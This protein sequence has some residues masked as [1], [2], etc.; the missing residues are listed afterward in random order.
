M[1]EHGRINDGGENRRGGKRHERGG[2]QASLKFRVS[3]FDRF[4]SGEISRRSEYRNIAMAAAD[5]Q[6]L[7]AAALSRNQDRFVDQ[8]SLPPFYAF[9]KAPME[10]SATMVV[11]ALRCVL[12]RRDYR[13]LS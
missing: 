7:A 4:S 2:R 3:L 11:T 5:R 13:K 10:T 9:V 6:F 1:R 8:G 12:V